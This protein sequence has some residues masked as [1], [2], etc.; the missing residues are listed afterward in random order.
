MT[1]I[2][3]LI[4]VIITPDE[5]NSVTAFSYSYGL[6]FTLST[7]NSLF[8]FGIVNRNVENQRKIWVVSAH[9][10]GL[11]FSGLAT[12]PFLKTLSITDRTHLTP[13]QIVTFIVFGAIFAWLGYRQVKFGM[14]NADKKTRRI[15]MIAG[16]IGILSVY[17]FSTA[18][19]CLTP[20]SK[21]HFHLHHAISAA[22]LSVF[23]T[24]WATISDIICHGVLIGVV[25]QGI[26]FYNVGEAYL[27]VVDQ[28]AKVP[29]WFAASVWLAFMILVGSRY[30]LSCLTKKKTQYVLP[31][32]DEYSV[33]VVKN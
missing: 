32:N 24:D 26:S 1:T 16:Y 12:V 33:D 15:P 29:L 21:S 20:G 11:G 23:W 9:V 7:V 19:I 25:A 17:A 18:I 2:F 4:P 27:Y 6:L 10:G 13:P 31:V 22:L 8:S 30:V 5:H 14:C 3:Q 28:D